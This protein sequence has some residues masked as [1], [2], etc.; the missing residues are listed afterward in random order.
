MIV[1]SLGGDLHNIR[2]YLYLNSVRAPATSVVGFPNMR[3][4]PNM[5]CAINPLP[6]MASPVPGRQVCRVDLGHFRC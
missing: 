3:K 2:G 1:G 6:Y 4:W 5:L